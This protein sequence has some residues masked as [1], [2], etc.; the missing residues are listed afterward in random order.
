MHACSAKVDVVPRKAVL[1]S[2]ASS[3]IGEATA[4]SLAQNGWTVFSGVRSSVDRQR[5]KQAHPSIHPIQL[6]LTSKND[7]SDAIRAV[8]DIVG[9]AGLQGLINNGG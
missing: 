5:L 3:G 6:D 8:S 4:R 7:I 9:D 2:G 1:I